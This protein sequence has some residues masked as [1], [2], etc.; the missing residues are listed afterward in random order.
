M[1]K[2]R[3]AYRDLVGK[4][5]GNIPLRRP[6]CRWEHNIKMDLKRDIMDDMD[7]IDLAQDGDQ[8]RALVNTIIKLRVTKML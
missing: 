5:E 7:W 4:P 1:Q 2:N 8:W 6:G 3:N